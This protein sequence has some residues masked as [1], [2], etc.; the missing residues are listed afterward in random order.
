MF[1]VDDVNV[2]VVAVVVVVD[3]VSLDVV[4]VFV[5]AAIVVVIK[6]VFTV[7]TFL[8]FYHK[9]FND[10]IFSCPI[11]FRPFIVTESDTKSDSLAICSSVQSKLQQAHIF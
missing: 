11:S 6:F 8:T 3:V 4:D 10:C 7:Y 5:I 1:F 9:Y 2:V